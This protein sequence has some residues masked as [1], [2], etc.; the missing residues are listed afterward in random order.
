MAP[1]FTDS[2]HI[3]RPCHLEP[4]AAQSIMPGE[5]S[6]GDPPMTARKQSKKEKGGRQNLCSLQRQT[7]NDTTSFH[8]ATSLGSIIPKR[9]TGW[10]LRHLGTFC[11]W[12]LGSF[13]LIVQSACRPSLPIIMTVGEL[14]KSPVSKAQDRLIS[15]TL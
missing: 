15:E 9:S 12:V 6:R 11:L 10:G 13:H 1:G 4:M 14:L 5:R 8:S 7:C 2:A 3:I